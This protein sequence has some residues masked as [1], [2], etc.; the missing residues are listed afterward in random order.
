M[1]D[2]SFSPLFIGETIVTL[3]LE[4]DYDELCDLSVPFSSGKR[5]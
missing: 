5:L 3:E 1:A 4:V 2:N